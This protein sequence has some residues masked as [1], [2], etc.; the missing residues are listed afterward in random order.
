MERVKYLEEIIEEMELH[1]LDIDEEI[2][3]ELNDLYIALDVYDSWKCKLA[4]QARIST[5]NAMSPVSGAHSADF[6]MPI[7]IPRVM[8]DEYL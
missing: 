6:M 4:E 1:G 7:P 2:D 5:L 8:Q 3:D